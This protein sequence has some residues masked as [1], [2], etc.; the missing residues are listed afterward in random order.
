[1]LTAGELRALLRAEGLRLTKRL[2][3][4]HLIDARLIER[5]VDASGVGGHDTVFEIGPGLGALTESLA[6]RAGRV[7]AVEVDRRMCT[8]LSKRLAHLQNV[9]VVCADVLGFDWERLGGVSVVGAIPYQ[10]TSPIL[11]TLCEH[12]R[13]IGRAVLVVQR[14]VAQRLT[15]RPGTKAYGRLSVLGQYSWEITQVLSIPRCAFFPQPKVDSICLRFLPMAIPSVRVLDERAFFELVRLAFAH[16]RKTLANCLSDPRAGLLARP[17]AQALLAG[18]GLPDGVRGERLSV[19]QFAR[20]ANA[21]S[22][23]KGAAR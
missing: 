2:G 21:L 20:L 4:H 6:Q 15:A 17:E 5:I 10:L 14:E 13:L 11:A 7:I 18:A 23:V 16:R 3:Q 12:R 19:A 8:L 1:M 22:I 9:H